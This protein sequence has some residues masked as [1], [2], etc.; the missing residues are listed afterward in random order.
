[1]ST[2]K[3]CRLVVDDD[4]YCIADRNIV[5]IPMEDC[6]HEWKQVKNEDTYGAWECK[7]CNGYIEIGVWE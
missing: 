2:K 4:V 6:E 7:K 1:M 3:D 5:R